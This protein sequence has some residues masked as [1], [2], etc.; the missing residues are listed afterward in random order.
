MAMIDA[1]NALPHKEDEQPVLLG[2]AEKE[3]ILCMRDIG[4][5]APS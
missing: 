2:Y 1:A 3:R 5:D 4:Q